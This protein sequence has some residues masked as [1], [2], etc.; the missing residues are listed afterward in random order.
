[1]VDGVKLMLMHWGGKGGGNNNKP[2]C[3]KNTANNIIMVPE[4]IGPLW[5]Q[6]VPERLSCYS[7]HMIY[8]GGNT[9]DWPH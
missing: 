6:Y 9:V 5:A 3:K 7:Q 8:M 1:M 2:L 4:C